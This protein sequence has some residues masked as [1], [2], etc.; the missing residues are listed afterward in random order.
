MVVVVAVAVVLVSIFATLSLL[1]PSVLLVL[2]ALISELL[3]LRLLLSGSPIRLRLDSSLS[4]SGRD[5]ST[6]AG[7]AL[8]KFFI[9]AIARR[10]G[11]FVELLASVL[12]ALRTSLEMFQ[13]MLYI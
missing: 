9:R 6:A 12:V 8:G 11:C 7:G 3:L 1:L 10:A 4:T 5:S 2:I 13:K